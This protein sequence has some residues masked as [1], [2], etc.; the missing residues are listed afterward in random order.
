M[1]YILP[2]PAC[3]ALYIPGGLYVV[4]A[5]V[6]GSLYNIL[7]LVDKMRDFWMLSGLLLGVVLCPDPSDSFPLRGSSLEPIPE[8]SSDNVECFLDYMELWVPR[9]MMDGLLLWL[10]RVMR[11]PVSLSSL[12]R[13]N[14]L[15]SRCRYLLEIDN[16]RNFIFR[17]HYTA[18]NVQT[19]KGFHILEIHMMKKTSTGNSRS[20][21]YMMRCPA[22]T[23][24]LGRARVRCDPTYVQVSRPLPLGNSDVKDWY[25]TLHGELLVAV[26][27]A[28][29][30]GMEVEMNNA[31]VKVRGL[32]DQL[33]SPR[34]FLDRQTAVLPLWLAHGFY[35]Y[36]ME[37]SC[38]PVSQQPGEEVVL[39]IPKQ[40]VGLV[41]R[42]S[43]MAETLTLKNIAPA[44]PLNVTVTED[45]QFVMISIPANEVLRQQDCP[46]TGDDIRR[47]QTYYSIDLVLQFAEI[48]YP[49]NWTVENYYQ[50]LVPEDKSRVEG[51]GDATEERRGSEKIYSA[52]IQS[53][54]AKSSLPTKPAVPPLFSHEGQHSAA[55]DVSPENKSHHVR[56][57]QDNPVIGVS[58][59]TTDNSFEH[60]SESVDLDIS[61]SGDSESQQPNQ[62]WSTEPPEVGSSTPDLFSESS[63]NESQ[64][65]FLSGL[66]SPTEILGGNR[67]LSMK[68]INPGERIHRPLEEKE[69]DVSLVIQHEAFGHVGFRPVALPPAAKYNTTT[70][71]SQH[72]LQSLSKN[73]L[74]TDRPELPARPRGG[75]DSQKTDYALSEPLDVT[76]RDGLLSLSSTDHRENKKKG[77]KLIDED[78]VKAE[79]LLLG[80][81]EKTEDPKPLTTP[82]DERRQPRHSQSLSKTKTDRPPSLSGA[83]SPPS[84]HLRRSVVWSMP[85]QVQEMPTRTANE[86]EE[87]VSDEELLLPVLA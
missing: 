27:D 81:H 38:P 4:S 68:A 41:K 20:D 43:Y 73:V 25:L 75:G 12:D 33:L 46:S 32:R 14:H 76:T 37:A 71:P 16:N 55:P 28:S 57:S 64:P 56:D 1:R 44:P 15:L 30:I 26:E 17:V 47:V 69:P 19:Q 85:N 60:F 11:F 7:T 51:S 58:W 21:R 59:K 34:K 67:I 54:T 23:A 84:T 83:G 70:K 49:M 13:S 31:S 6:R 72:Q 78:E 80:G 82:E 24:E 8:S 29:L 48:A 63:F 10:S 3:G 45:R 35:A 53:S 5:Q 74:T 87:T 61:G 62:R 39:Y 50:C 9:R 86:I 18:C 65:L 40:R 52:S 42:A 79:S 36:S 66:F 77:D 2:P 22:L